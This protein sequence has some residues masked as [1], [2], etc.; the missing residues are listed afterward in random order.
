MHGAAGEDVSPSFSNVLDANWFAARNYTPGVYPGRVVLFKARDD[1]DDTRLDAQMGWGGLAA[2]GFEVHEI[3]GT[4]MGLFSSAGAAA[5]AVEIEGCLERLPE[6]RP[7][8]VPE[9][10]AR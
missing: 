4:H 7:L 2:E 10:S 9:A 3:P 8:V 6:L 1:K 5:L